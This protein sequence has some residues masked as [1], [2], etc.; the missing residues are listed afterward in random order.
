M[1]MRLQLLFYRD[2]VSEGEIAKVKAEECKA[3]QDAIEHVLRGAPPGVKV[4]PITVTFIVVGKRYAAGLESKAMLTRPRH[5]VRLFPE[6]IPQSATLARG[7]SEPNHYSGLIIG[8]RFRAMA[9]VSRVLSRPTTSG[10]LTC[11][12][13]GKYPKVSTAMRRLCSCK[14]SYRYSSE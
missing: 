12:M 6:H 8:G 1:L 7:E 11:R 9:T 3:I 4:D 14:P 2:G 5:H 13:T 10:L